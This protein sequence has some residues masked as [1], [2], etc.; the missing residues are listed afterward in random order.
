MKPHTPK[1]TARDVATTKDRTL[2][3]QQR[4]NEWWREGRPIH[5]F[6]IKFVGVLVALHAVTLLPVFD[7]M[8]P[9]YL[10]AVAVMAGTLTHCFGEATTVMDVTLRSS[11]YAVTVAPSCSAVELACYIG[12]AVIAFPS[13]WRARVSGFFIGFCLVAIL[14]VIRVT[15]LFLVGVHAR[16]AFEVAH[17][18]V[19]AVLLISATTLFVAGWIAWVTQPQAP[20]VKPADEY[21]AG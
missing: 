8:L 9:F 10:H 14:N 15:S 2:S 19:W 1:E 20:P 16:S 21:A 18:D 17:D 3:R 11:A 5:L 7:R 4:W 6:I 12:A 13:P